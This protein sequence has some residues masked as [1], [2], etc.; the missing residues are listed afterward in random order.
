MARTRRFN[1]R[2]FK[3]PDDTVIEYCWQ[4][5]RNIKL[6]IYKQYLN[7][8]NKPLGGELK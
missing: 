6:Q 2:I 3:H 1:V 8:I 4:F 7:L 5:I